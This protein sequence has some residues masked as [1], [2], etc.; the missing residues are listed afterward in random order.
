[1]IIAFAV[2]IF[3]GFCA[4][5]L[6]G[7]EDSHYR[8]TKLLEEM[9]EQAAQRSAEAEQTTTVAPIMTTQ[10]TADAFGEM[11][12]TRSLLALNK[13]DSLVPCDS[14]KPV[15]V[16]SS[17]SESALPVRSRDRVQAL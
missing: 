6:I 15:R 9:D 17:S 3:I 10:Q 12:F 8:V 2:T 11:S 5:A 1:M 16:E 13:V 14:P 7:M 4:V